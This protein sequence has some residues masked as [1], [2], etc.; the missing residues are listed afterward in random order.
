MLER[1]KKYFREKKQEKWVQKTM[2]EN[3]EQLIPVDTLSILTFED[4]T[5]SE[6]MCEFRDGVN[7]DYFIPLIK[8]NGKYFEV[9]ALQEVELN[10]DLTLSSEGEKLLKSVLYN[11]ENLK[12]NKVQDTELRAEWRG[13]G[14]GYVLKLKYNEGLLSSNSHSYGYGIE[15]DICRKCSTL[16][17]SINKGYISLNQLRFASDQIW[18]DELDKYECCL[19]TRTEKAKEKQK[20]EESRLFI[21][22]LGKSGM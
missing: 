6:H 7:V 18:A 11:L 21:D 14:Y 8:S 16:S 19:K 15:D 3:S 13:S 12:S 5:K 17:E 4:T 9:K 2:E 1:L 10:E 20:L 22:K